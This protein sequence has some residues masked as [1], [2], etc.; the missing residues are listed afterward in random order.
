LAVIVLLFFLVMDLNGRVANLNR[1]T[2]ERD[3]AGTEVAQLQSTADA[4]TT[5]IAYATSEVAVE[6]WARDK[7]RMVRPGDVAIVPV[8]PEGYTP[9]P[10]V[11]VTPTL[12]P[13]E[14]WQVWRILFFGK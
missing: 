12:E 7:G 4:L 10:V 9:Q 2:N 14:N 13:V 6:D 1:L 11:T 5:Q 8:A 3:M